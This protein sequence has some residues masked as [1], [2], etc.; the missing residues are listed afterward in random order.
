MANYG[1]E[2]KSGVQPS[3]ICMTCKLKMFFYILN[4]WGNQK[5]NSTWKTYMN[6]DFSVH[7]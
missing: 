5:I 3:L 7:Q 6:S 4:S 2:A 1:P